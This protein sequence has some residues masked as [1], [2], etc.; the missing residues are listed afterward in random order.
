MKLL[1]KADIFATDDRQTVDVAVPEWG[2]DAG[3]RCRSLT[4]AEH[5]T[6]AAGIDKIDD[7]ATIA[8]HLVVATAIGGDGLPMFTLEDVP[9]LAQKSATAVKR[10]AKEAMRLNAMGKDA[11]EEAKK[12]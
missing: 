5:K 6:F 11:V 1:T 3:V 7:D 10:I 12:N 4:V 9:A 8:A 2:A